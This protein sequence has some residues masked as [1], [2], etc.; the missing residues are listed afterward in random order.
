MRNNVDPKV[1]NA[2][3]RRNDANQNLKFKH[4]QYGVHFSVTRS[5]KY[6]SCDHEKTKRY[7]LF[8]HAH[9]DKMR[10]LENIIS[11]VSSFKFIKYI[12][13]CNIHRHENKF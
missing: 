8:F 3:K 4:V 5:S 13:V 2:Y 7:F 1:Y 11:K 10:I 12:S 9:L 6:F